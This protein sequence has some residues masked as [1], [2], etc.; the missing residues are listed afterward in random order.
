M[1]CGMETPCGIARLYDAEPTTSLGWKSLRI[2]QRRN[3]DT[4][5]RRR[6][7]DGFS[8]LHFGVMFVD[9]SRGPLHVWLPCLKIRARKLVRSCCIGWGMS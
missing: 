3:S 4:H 6:V 9:E 1:T 7:E 8:L 2:T 5:A